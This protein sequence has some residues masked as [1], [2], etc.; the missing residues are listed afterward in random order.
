MLPDEQGYTTGR[1]STVVGAVDDDPQGD[2]DLSEASLI[3][4]AEAATG[5]T[6]F[7]RPEFRVGLRVAVAALAESGLPTALVAM[8]RRSF[9]GHL[10]TRLRIIGLRNERPGIAD[11]VID[12]PVV[13]IG[14]PRTGTTALVD[15]LAR[16]PAVRAP[17]QWEV[18]N[19]FP[20]ADKARWAS[21]PRIATTQAAF[22]VEA[23]QSELVRLGL[24][25]Y[26]AQLPDECN[27]FLSL[28]F[29]S[30]NLS[31]LG[32]MTRYSEWCEYAAPAEPYRMHHHVL[33]QLQAF[34]PGGRWLLKSPYHAFDLPALVAEY[35]TAILVQTHRDP[36]AMMASMCG[37]FATIRGQGPDDEAAR[38]NTGREILD[39][40]S[41]GMRRCMAARQDPV[42]DARILDIS[43]RAVLVDPLA[44]VRSVYERFDLPF[45]EEAER[46][47][48]AWIANPVQHRSK[49]TFTLEEFGL[50]AGEVRAAF[51]PYCDRFGERL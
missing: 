35:P 10:V 42:L 23:A 18:Q 32:G 26:G 17:L 29:R 12:G 49:V 30:P 27:T 8:L 51:G 2:L 6:D 22:D 31:T 46:A 36:T 40:W 15:L 7:G 19:L 9:V 20:P 43:H 44:A 4:E 24:H 48:T 28:D 1:M 37:M 41:T 11:E 25:T 45:T 47:I 3:A 14:M 33:Q 13:V 38:A 16:D 34:G 39:Y 50:D 5:L 21:D